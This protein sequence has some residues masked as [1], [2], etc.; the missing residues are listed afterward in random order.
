ML[1]HRAQDAELEA[2]SVCA[3]GVV[4]D[5]KELVASL[6]S[7]L[8]SS[9]EGPERAVEF[10]I[11]VGRVLGISARVLHVEQ[12]LQEV[13]GVELLLLGIRTERSFHIVLGPSHLAV[14]LAG[15]LA[16]GG[17]DFRSALL[18]LKSLADDAQVVG[19]APQVG[20]RVGGGPVLGELVV[21]AVV[22]GILVH[23]CVPDHPHLQLLTVVI[24]LDQLEVGE[25][26]ALGASARGLLLPG[27]CSHRAPVAAP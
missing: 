20:V 23:V 9:L 18:V 27:G 14:P 1:I 6:R 13:G 3:K 5:D 7:C 8:A 22:V 2:V 11:L 24:D 16:E 25:D 15:K 21:V 10:A 26:R 19:D 4:K 12:A 17:A